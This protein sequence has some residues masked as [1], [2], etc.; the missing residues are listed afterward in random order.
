MVFLHLAHGSGLSYRVTTLTALR[1]AAAWGKLVERVDTGDLR[2]LA[3]ATDRLRHDVSA[4]MLIPLP[5]APL[6]TIEL[7]TVPTQPQSHELTLFM[8][9]TMWPY[10]GKLEEYI[11]RSGA[12]YFQEMQQPGAILEIQAG[13]RSAFGSHR[14][15]EIV[16]LQKAV[17]P[18]RIIHLLMT[19]IPEEMRKPGSWM[20]DGLKLRDQWQSRLL[21]TSAWSPWF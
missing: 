10:E 3:E 8:E 14:R 21:R 18:Q 7:E 19:E 15:R 12:H 6:Q 2:E 11:Q 4:K 5:W 17:D 9:D 13:F 20:L 1:D 16:L